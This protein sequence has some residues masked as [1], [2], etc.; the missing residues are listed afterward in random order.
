MEPTN[1]KNGNGNSQ[2]DTTLPGMQTEKFCKEFPTV[3]TWL[4]YRWLTED[5]EPR[6]FWEGPGF[7]ELRTITPTQMYAIQQLAKGNSGFGQKAECCTN[8]GSLC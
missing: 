3:E 5:E 7:D 8:I 4:T 1:Y 6:I 2:G